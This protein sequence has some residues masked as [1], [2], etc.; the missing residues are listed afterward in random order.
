MINP[1]S[2]RIT[3]PSGN[4]KTPFPESQNMGK[5][6]FARD[7]FSFSSNTNSKAEAKQSKNILELLFGN[8]HKKNKHKSRT[9]NKYEA[10]LY[11]VPRNEAELRQFME[12]YEP[13][14][15]L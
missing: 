15:K 10:E 7:S 8:V 1:L 9:F 3:I 14:L 5:A 13:Q 12:N 11:A 4:V 6:S 2:A